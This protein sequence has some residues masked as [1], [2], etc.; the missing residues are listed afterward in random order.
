M[1]CKAKHIKQNK[2]TQN[3][4]R[5]K[6]NMI[7]S[8]IKPLNNSTSTQRVVHLQLDSFVIPTMTCPQTPQ[9]TQRWHPKQNNTRR[10]DLGHIP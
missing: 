8:R 2:T 3:T 9:K 6:Q 10:K 5:A 1:Q 4:T 7:N